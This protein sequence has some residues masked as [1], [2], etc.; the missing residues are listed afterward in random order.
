MCY[1]VCIVKYSFFVFLGC[2]GCNVIWC[3]ECSEWCAFC[4][5]CDACVLG[6]A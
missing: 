5:S 3:S 4:L 1:V 6:V 2:C